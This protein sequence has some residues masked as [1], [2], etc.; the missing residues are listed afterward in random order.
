MNLLPFNT[1]SKLNS[2]LR[3]YCKHKNLTPALSVSTLRMMV[4]CK[5]P[6]FRQ[7]SHQPAYFADFQGQLGRT[8]S[9]TVFMSFR[10]PVALHELASS[11]TIISVL[12]NR[13]NFAHNS[14]ISL[15]PR[16]QHS[17]THVFTSDRLCFNSQNHSWITLARKSKIRNQSIRET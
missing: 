11:P 1:S 14:K 4:H 16:R 6:L 12:I 15:Q 8:W 13:L 3:S 7:S 10:R 5:Y 17:R 9:A 2:F